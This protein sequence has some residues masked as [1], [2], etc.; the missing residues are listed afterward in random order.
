MKGLAPQTENLFH[1]IAALPC[2]QHFVLVGGTAL[3]MQLGTR[4]SEDLDFMKWRVA[5]DE[6]MDV[7]WP[8][9]KRELESVASVD[10]MNLMD[11]DHVEFIV[12]GVKVSFYAAGRYAPPMKPILIKENIRI[13]DV[14]AIG[15][16]KMEVLLRRATFRDYYDIYSIILSGE[17]LHEMIQMAL[18]H[19]DHRLKTKQLIA[20]LTNG[21]H[22]SRD[23]RFEYLSPVYNVSPSD[24]EQYIKALLQP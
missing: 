22:F 15:V 12:D 14:R 17:D 24:I 1:R 6:A 8:V 9:I 10:S 5:K 19:S 20:M 18:A 23:A 4:L 7:N 11:F 3:A 2:L 21:S 16:M 13:A